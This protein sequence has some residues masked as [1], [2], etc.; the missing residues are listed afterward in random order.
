MKTVTVDQAKLMARRIILEH[1][2][3]CVRD[4][5]GFILSSAKAAAK[6]T[7]RYIMDTQHL[8]YISENQYY[9]LPEEER[10]APAERHW[11]FWEKVLQEIET[12]KHE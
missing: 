3:H 2:E 11:W 12:Y 4:N 6:L 1:S 5:I 7:V 9:E 8:Y 10:F